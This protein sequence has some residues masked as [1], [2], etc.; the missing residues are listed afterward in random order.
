MTE[1]RELEAWRS[2]W[3]A[4][5]GREELARELAE[6]AKRGAAKQRRA[7][8][9]EVVASVVA[10][11]SF[12]RMAIT[13][14]GAPVITALCAGAFFF[15]G[16]WL[17]K[18]FAI[19]GPK[20]GATSVDGYVDVLR[21][22]LDKD[23]RWNDFARRATAALGLAIVPWSLWKVAADW[24]LYR[25]EPWRF[26]VGFGGVVVILAGL[27]FASTKKRA[28]LA[29]ERERFESLVAERTLA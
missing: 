27:L 19:F 2:E 5:G 26:V 3:Q 25:A 28:R 1:E 14:R 9:M 20:D 11:A 24:Q 16:I 6:R 8:M 10:N 18:L 4:L 23:A 7:V 15:S 21:A 17:S 22:Q 12:L 29:E 13:S